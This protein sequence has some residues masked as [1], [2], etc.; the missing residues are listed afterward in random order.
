MPSRRFHEKSRHGCTQCKFRKVKC[1]DQRPVCGNCARREET[2]EFSSLALVSSSRRPLTLRPPPVISVIAAQPSAGFTLQDLELLHHFST[3]VCFTLA[4]QPKLQRMWQ[5]S[6]PKAA[7]SHAF[8]MHCL[9]AVSA[10]HLV[11]SHLG[12]CESY[13][14]AAVKHQD[15]SLSLFRPQLHHVTPE[16]C[17]ALIACASLLVV[18]ALLPGMSKKQ[19]PIEDILE[20]CQLARG[21]HEIVKAGGN[22]IA[23]GTLEPLLR[24]RSWDDSPPLT[25]DVS[26]A[27]EQLDRVIGNLS[28]PEPTRAVYRVA[29][30]GLI[31]A[32]QASMLNPDHQSV[33]FLWLVFIDRPYIELLRAR[34]PMAL[35]IL[36][37]YSVVIHGS[38]D[39]FW[40]QDLGFRLVEAVYAKLPP[41]WRHLISWP[42]RTVGLD[43]TWSHPVV[44]PFPETL[45]VV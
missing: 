9:L 17:E 32:F 24:P 44:A 37:H 21:V 11:H 22:Q 41:D 18:L 39:I 16:N 40:S 10:A 19:D 45:G 42:L 33:V 28:E 7:A 43:W 15:L 30:H 38:K 1:D 8:L 5:I 31:K 6:V 26:A 23:A 4:G 36:A 35:V 3:V 34:E 13:R 25:Q 2:C 20:I 14:I 12:D 27:L 29:S